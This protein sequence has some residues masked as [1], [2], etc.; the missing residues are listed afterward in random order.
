MWE[1]DIETGTKKKL[2]DECVFDD[3]LATENYLYCYRKDYLLP[4]GMANDWYKGYSLKQI[5]IN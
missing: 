2:S 1:V 4:R 5:P 3:L